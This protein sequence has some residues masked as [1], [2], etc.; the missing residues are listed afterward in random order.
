MI[1]YMYMYRTFQYIDGSTTGDLHQPTDSMEGHETLIS[2][3]T[4]HWF[5]Y[6]S[7]DGGLPKHRA[8]SLD[9]NPCTK[10]IRVTRTPRGKCFTLNGLQNDNE[11]KNSIS[12]G[13]DQG[14]KVA[15]DIGHGDM[16]K[17]FATDQL[18]HILVGKCLRTLVFL[19]F[20]I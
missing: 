2:R 9:R 6:C 4:E 20:K 7:Y 13:R 12:V 17:K 19:G 14:F 10:S 15:I 18:D 11:I 3:D 5:P 1:L 16:G 8:S